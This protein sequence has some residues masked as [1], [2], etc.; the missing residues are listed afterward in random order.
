MAQKSKDSINSSRSDYDF[1]EECPEFR[2][3]LL[4]EFIKRAGVK[5]VLL[6]SD[7]ELAPLNAAG[8]ITPPRKP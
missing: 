6:L 3:R 5:E 2:A 4:T 8:Q 1:S 7:E